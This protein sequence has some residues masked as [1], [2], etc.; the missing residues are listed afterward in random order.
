LKASELSVKTHH[1]LAGLFHRAGLPAGVLN[2]IQARREDASIVTEALIAH[3]GI[4][5][6]EFIGSAPVGRAIGALAG[7]HLKP[8]LMELGGKAAALV[9]DDAD[10]ELAANGCVIGAFTHSGQVCFSTERVIINSAVVEK[11]IVLLKEAA[12]KFQGS[13]RV[14]VAGTRAAL[15]MQEDAVA[16]GAKI[17][18]GEVKLLDEAI[19]HPLIL[20]GVTSEMQIYD[21]ESFG[22][23]LAVYEVDSD[24]EAIELANNSRS[25][26]SA[27]IYSKDI[28]RALTIA[29]KIEVGQTHINFP[30]GTGW[31]ECEF[32]HP[33]MECNL[34]LTVLLATFTI[35][36][37]KES[38][39]G[40]QNGD[41][42]LD[43]FLDLRAVL[44]TNPPEFFH[45][46]ATST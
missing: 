11:F 27:G 23:V 14:S 17:I 43:E 25:G 19:L 15:S 46:M 5:K 10:L 9:L 40:K 34:L 8:I 2:V 37:C 45:G 16:K 1:Y 13:G 39:Y 38:G 41:Y 21:K 31:E 24:E 22:P 44:I 20:S 33:Q 36:M 26:L 29:S 30:F 7:K 35:G 28:T 42:G 3:P 12:A 6:I 4:R 18:Y 32:D